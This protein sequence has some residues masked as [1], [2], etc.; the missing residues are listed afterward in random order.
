MIVDTYLVNGVNRGALAPPIAVALELLGAH[1]IVNM[2]RIVGTMDLNFSPERCRII[3]FTFS[4][5]PLI[6]RRNEIIRSF[7]GCNKAPSVL[8]AAEPKKTT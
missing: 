6:G 8:L 5:K 2:V 3:R 1:T 4:R 7:F